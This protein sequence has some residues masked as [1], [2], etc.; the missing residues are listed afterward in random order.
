V[1]WKQGLLFL[2][3]DIGACGGFYRTPLRL[4]ELAD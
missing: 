4:P 3:R 1:L 2:A